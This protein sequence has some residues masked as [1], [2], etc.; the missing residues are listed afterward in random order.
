MNLFCKLA[1]PER[2]CACTWDL[3]ADG[4]GRQVWVEFFKRHFKTILSLGVAAEVRR[5]QSEGAARERAEQCQERFYRI[6]DGFARDPQAHGRVDIL[7]FDAWR[8]GLLREHGFADPFLDVKN[9]ENEKILPMLPVVCRQ[10]DALSGPEQAKAVIEGV[11]AGNIY[12]LGSEA[13]ARSFLGASPDFFAIR[14]KLAPRPWLMDDF[15]A[16]VERLLSPRGYG[17]MVFFI[18]NAGSDFLLGA[19]PMMRWMARR[20][21]RVVLAANELPTLNDMT[22]HDVRAWWPRILQ[23][24][25][26]LADLPIE[27]VST[28]TAEPLIDLRRVS[29]ELNAACAEADL[30]VLEGMGRAVESNLEAEFACDSLKIAMVKMAAVAERLGGKLYDLVCRFALAT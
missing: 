10:L 15:D 17:K 26:S 2:Y 11:F 19:L 21:T 7:T 1:N 6:M 3:T 16:L 14:R 13:T 8:D 12:D 30:V 24:E 18:D 25:R 4:R 28:G 9:Q 27:L 23:A 20:G 22:I 5:G 29:E